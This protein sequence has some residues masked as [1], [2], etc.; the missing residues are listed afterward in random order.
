MAL[1][2]KSTSESLCASIPCSKHCENVPSHAQ[3]FFYARIA[4]LPT[5]A[6]CLMLTRS[7]IAAL[8]FASL[9]GAV[10]NAQ[11][12]AGIVGASPTSGYTLRSGDIVRLRIWREP[13]LSGDFPV[14]ELG[15]VNLPLV[16]TYPVA[17]ETRE[18]LHQK[19]VAAYRASVQNLSMDVIF[20]RRIPVI[21]AVRTPGLYPI[22]PTMTVADAVALAGGSM[23]SADR[24]S[25]AL[26]RGG[27]VHEKNVNPAVTVSSL[28]MLPGDQLYVPPASGL[29]D[30]N[31]WMA[32]TIIQSIVT[33][34][35]AAITIAATK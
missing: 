35:V 32:S 3:P 34:T 31:P 14:D 5:A 21:G 18:S 1:S 9:A 28:L 8:L 20:L 7:A 4:A 10:C 17:D 22:D 25:V 19:L 24:T 29:F 11:T 23:L 6:Q 27:R 15:R 26:L 2:F 12:T 16:G 13:D 30:R 33:I